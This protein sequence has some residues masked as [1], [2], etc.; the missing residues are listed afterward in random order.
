M[1]RPLAVGLFF[2]GPLVWCAEFGSNVPL[3]N[4]RLPWYD[5]AAGRVTAEVSGAEG[6]LIENG[7]AEITRLRLR[8]LG[9]EGPDQVTLEITSPLA[10]VDSESRTASGPGQ[11]RVKTPEFEIY[12]DDWTYDHNTRTAIIRRDVVATFSYDLGNLLP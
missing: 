2:I 1:K 11:L 3:M 5:D 6:K 12:G 10:V 8:A 4:F 7:R 9:P